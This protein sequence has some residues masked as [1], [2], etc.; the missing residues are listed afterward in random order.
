MTS[1]C[2]LSSAVDEHARQ[3]S[4]QLIEDAAHATVTSCSKVATQQFRLTALCMWAHLLCGHA[5]VKMMSAVSHAPWLMMVLSSATSGL[6]C[7]KACCTSGENFSSSGARL[8]ASCRA[9]SCRS[10][11]KIL[12]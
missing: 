3:R 9:C 6:P 11:S 8:L 5:C 10:V 7:C 1:Q 4:G 2:R 12:L